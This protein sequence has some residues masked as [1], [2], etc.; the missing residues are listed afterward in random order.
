MLWYDDQHVRRLTCTHTHIHTHT[1][2]Q[3]N[4]HVKHTHTH[5]HK[6]RTRTR[7]KSIHTQRTHT[8][9]QLHSHLCPKAF[10]KGQRG[11]G[12]GHLYSRILP[13][14]GNCNVHSFVCKCTILRMHGRETTNKICIA[15]PLYGF[16]AITAQVA[17][18]SFSTDK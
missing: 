10:C 12:W 15:L 13:I 1:H 2:T 4:T 18:I 8:C 5:T 11:Q 16:L 17:S 14:S 7:K 3:T 9:I 6:T